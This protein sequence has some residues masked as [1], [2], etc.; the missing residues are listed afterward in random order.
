MK[1]T[2]HSGLR[3]LNT[4]RGLKHERREYRPPEPA[5]RRGP[6][7]CGRARSLGT[8][9][10]PT[11][12]FCVSWQNRLVAVPWRL[13]RHQTEPA[14]DRSDVCCLLT[15]APSPGRSTKTLGHTLSSNQIPT[16]RGPSDPPKCSSEPSASAAEHTSG[17]SPLAGL[18]VKDLHMVLHLVGV[19]INGEIIKPA[20]LIKSS[21]SPVGVF[22][23]VN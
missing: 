9:G 14:S 19:Q 12:K 5:R 16:C 15:I 6:R 11:C 21:Q 7:S 13:A 2:T 3:P 20:I 18:D 4:Q 23:T 1:T 10:R 8:A 17:Q 22:E